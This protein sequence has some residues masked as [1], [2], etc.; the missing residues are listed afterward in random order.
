MPGMPKRIAASGRIQRNLNDHFAQSQNRWEVL[1]GLIEGKHTLFEL[2]I[3]RR[4]VSAADLK[5]LGE[6]WFGTYWKDIIP[7]TG[8]EEILEAGYRKALERSFGLG[9]DD[10]YQ[11][12]ALTNGASPPA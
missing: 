11:P 9:R 12:E 8:R 6:K 7:M 5:D 2:L 10:W 4:A 1:R 3:Q